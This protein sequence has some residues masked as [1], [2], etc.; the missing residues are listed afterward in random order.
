MQQWRLR[1][2]AIDSKLKMLKKLKLTVDHQV[3]Q[4]K[5]CEILTAKSMKLTAHSGCTGS[6]APPAWDIHPRRF[7]VFSSTV[8][9][10]MEEIPG[11]RYLL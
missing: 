11:D 7:A 2:L 6:R 1:C 5:V 3:S 10:A 4:H 8:T 9:R